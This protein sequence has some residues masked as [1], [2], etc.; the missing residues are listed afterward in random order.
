MSFTAR[1][2]RSCRLAPVSLNRTIEQVAVSHA[3]LRWRD[4]PQR[5]GIAIGVA[6]GSSADV[7]EIMGVEGEI[8][9]ALTNLIFN[10]VDA[11][12]DGGAITLRTRFLPAEPRSRPPRLGPGSSSK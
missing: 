4:L 9:D 12:P 10:A 1:A 6:A 5:R 2:S 11:M 7:P 3:V 8:R